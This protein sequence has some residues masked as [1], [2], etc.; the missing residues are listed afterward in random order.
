[1]DEYQ[2][3]PDDKHYFDPFI[4]LLGNVWVIGSICL[5]SIIIGV[6]LSIH[7]S[8]WIWFS[9]FGAIVTIA[10]LLLSNSTVFSDGIYLSH[11]AN[12]GI[13]IRTKEKFIKKTTPEIRE[14]GD[15]VFYGILF[16][17]LGTVIWGFGDLTSN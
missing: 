2:T 5:L 10:G 6:A 9:R 13:P 11:G 15:R 7:H 17:I 16:T 1:M 14:K 3:H 4:R 8:E 12:G